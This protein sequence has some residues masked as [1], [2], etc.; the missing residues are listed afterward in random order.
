M[1]GWKDMGGWQCYVSQIVAKAGSHKGDSCSEVTAHCRERKEVIPCF[2]L[3]PGSS[4]LSP[5][6][7]WHRR[8]ENHD[9][10]RPA[11]PPEIR[12]KQLKSEEWVR[13]QEVR[14]K[15]I[16][17]LYILTDIKFYISLFCISFQFCWRT[18]P[19]L[20]HLSVY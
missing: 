16:T 7:S 18:L 13:D 17:K 10:Q 6:V 19:P 5:E 11:L 3:L 14:G 9:H 15:I 4:S 1:L 12:P 20:L 2:S 8:L